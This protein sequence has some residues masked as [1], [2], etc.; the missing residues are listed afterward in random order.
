MKKKEPV[1]QDIWGLEAAAQS[2]DRAVKAATDAKKA[3]KAKKDFV[4]NH[5]DYV[6]VIKEGDD[7][8]LSKIPELYHENLKT[9]GVID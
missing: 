8:D 7:L 1:Q 9:E 3:K 5:N 4:I 6:L 2:R